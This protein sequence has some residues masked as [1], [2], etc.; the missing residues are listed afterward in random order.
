MCA[1]FFCTVFS[2][3]SVFPFPFT[4]LYFLYSFLSGLSAG[5]VFYSFSLK[6]SANSVYPSAVI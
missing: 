2:F 6:N 5:A 1:P 3:G 4:G